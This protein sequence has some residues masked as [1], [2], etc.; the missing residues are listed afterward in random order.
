MWGIEKGFVSV[1]EHT[2]SGKQQSLRSLHSRPG[3]LLAMP[4]ISFRLEENF[5]LILKKKKFLIA[6]FQ[7]TGYCW[8]SLFRDFYLL[9]FR[10][11]QLI[12]TWSILV[13]SRPGLS[14]STWVTAIQMRRAC[15]Q[16]RC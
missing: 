16:V 9:P 7:V 10:I 3:L 1:L 11:R 12:L 8:K 2:G 6:R 14:F 5:V 15:A 13:P 4:S